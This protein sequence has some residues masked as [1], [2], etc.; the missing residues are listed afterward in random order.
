MP[1]NNDWLIIKVKGCRKAG[2]KYFKS[3]TEIPSWPDDDL[4]CKVCITLSKLDS[5]INWK[6][7]DVNIVLF[8]YTLKGFFPGY[9]GH[10][11]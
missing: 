5:S 7:N 8:K 1:V 9:D 3:L 10:S 11:W 2:A 4:V 6:S